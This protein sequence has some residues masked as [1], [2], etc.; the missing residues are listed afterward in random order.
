V[1]NNIQVSSNRENL[2]NLTVKSYSLARS[3]I[4]H[5]LADDDDDVWRRR[6]RTVLL[7]NIFLLKIFLF[8]FYDDPL[9]ASHSNALTTT[10]NNI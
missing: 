10:M 1:N 3:L 7:C 4:W 8:Y 6:H 5:L 9:T 2:H